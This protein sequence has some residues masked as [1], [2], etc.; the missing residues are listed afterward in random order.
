MNKRTALSLFMFAALLAMAG[1]QIFSGPGAPQ[2]KAV[3]PAICP[4]C[5][6]I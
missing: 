1:G 2:E 5:G 4:T 3:S 6:D